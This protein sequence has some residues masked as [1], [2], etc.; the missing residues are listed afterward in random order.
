MRIFCT[1]ASGY[2]GGSNAVALAAAGHE[3]SGLAW[4]LP[5]QAQ[6]TCYEASSVQAATDK[7]LDMEISSDVVYR[8]SCRAHPRVARGAAC[9][10]RIVSARVQR[11]FPRRLQ[12]HRSF[13]ARKRTHWSQRF[14]R[15]SALSAPDKRKK[16]KAIDHFR[17]ESKTAT[18]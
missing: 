18:Y 1:G 13:I 8:D 9:R 3:V 2:I 16:P 11:D 4:A 5:R 12:S 10:R 6:R 7:A 15:E 17:R 14:R